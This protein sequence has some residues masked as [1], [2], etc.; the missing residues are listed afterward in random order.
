MSNTVVAAFYTERKKFADTRSHVFYKKLTIKVIAY[1]FYRSKK[2]R[3]LK[4]VPR[5]TSQPIRKQKKRSTKDFPTYKKASVVARSERR[6]EN[7]SCASNSAGQVTDESHATFGRTGFILG[8]E[9]GCCSSIRGTDQHR[10]KGLP[11]T[12]HLRKNRA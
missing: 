3:K 8:D 6:D 1:L 2:T 5:A 9:P 11:G 12:E 4:E 7:K 10:I